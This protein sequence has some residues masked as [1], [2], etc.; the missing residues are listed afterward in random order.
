MPEFYTIK[1]EG[2]LPDYRSAW[3]G[4]VSIT[5]DDEGNTTLTGC[6]ADQAALYG[7]LDLLRDL[8]ITLLAVSRLEEMH[9]DGCERT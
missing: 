8:G 3:F 1:V 5:R 9:P 6:L 2:H 7:I 4:G